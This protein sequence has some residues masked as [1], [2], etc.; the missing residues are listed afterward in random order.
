VIEVPNPHPL[1][2][3]GLTYSNDG[4]EFY[5]P[6]PDLDIRYGVVTREEHLLQTVG[7]AYGWRVVCRLHRR[8]WSWVRD[9]DE[10]KEDVYAEGGMIHAQS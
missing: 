6:G 10:I 3:P 4:Q 7:T 2:P 5:C 9:D 1:D 8:V